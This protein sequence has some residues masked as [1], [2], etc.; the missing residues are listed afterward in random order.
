MHC[1]DARLSEESSASR[2]T[3]R[4][5]W[6]W[7]WLVT[8]GIALAPSAAWAQREEIPAPR[9]PQT[10]PPPP[11]ENAQD[12]QD[13]RRERRR[14]VFDLGRGLLRSLVNPAPGEAD[15]Q[16][17]PLDVDKLNDRFAGMIAAVLKNEPDIRTLRVW[18]D[19]EA[20]DLARD[21]VKVN[22]QVV[23]RR[24]AWSD[25]PS[26]LTLSISAHVEPGVVP[27]GIFS[28]Q[29]TLR[30]DTVALIDFARRTAVSLD[31][32]PQAE[33]GADA[34]F[35]AEA[36]TLAAATESLA[37]LDDVV[38]F[39]VNLG[40]LNIEA[41]SVEIEHLK[42]QLDAAPEG[43]QHVQLT[44]ELFAVRSR[45]DDL[46]TI[47]PK[48]T[49]DSGGL[50]QSFEVDLP[51]STNKLLRFDGA[52]VHLAGDLVDISGALSVDKGVALYYLTKPFVMGTLRKV[53]SGDEATLKQGG[54]L[55]RRG[56]DTA[57]EVL[58]PPPAESPDETP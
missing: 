2:P 39:I 45:R 47:R 3:A 52:H 30:T 7:I 1:Y 20:T 50:A 22:A 53:Q 36:L 17:E 37:A 11:A 48:I 14:R 18:L 19:R 46:L 41:H 10:Q 32:K 13:P 15:G 26:E 57:R 9:R 24:S 56:L 23:L 33:S 43:E 38:D 55:L 40:A 42:R 58:P 44:T 6:T 54:E 8:F 12:P 25:H 5:G 29:L 49:R 31:K 51:P 16:A 4:H 34:R 35:Q 21:R 27:R 28:G